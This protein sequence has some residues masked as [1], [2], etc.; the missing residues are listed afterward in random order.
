MEDR[1]SLLEGKVAERTPCSARLLHLL[2][3]AVI[4]AKLALALALEAYQIFDSI[5][6]RKFP[7]M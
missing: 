6:R 3:K 4:Q 7:Q 5:P 2:H 1:Q